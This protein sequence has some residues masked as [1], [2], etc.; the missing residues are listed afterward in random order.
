MA[1]EVNQIA[2]LVAVAGAEEVVE[3]HFQQCRERSIGGD[4]AADAVVNLVLM[5]HHGHGI[6]AHQ[7]FQFAL[8]H[9]VSGVGDFA[10]RRNRIDVVRGTA[11]R[12]ID[13]VVARSFSKLFEDVVDPVGSCCIDD[14]IQ[15]FQPLRCFAGVE[16]WHAF[17]PLLVHGF[18]HII[19][20]G[21]N[22]TGSLRTDAR[23]KGSSHE[24]SG[25][26]TFFHAVRLSGQKR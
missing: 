2:G 18:T 5:R 21:S 13:A 16:V 12:N 11:N 20:D 8:Q 26:R 19:S 15:S 4:V 24:K 7:T 6:P 17:S 14:L 9:T 25:G 22:W 23:M 10:L 1:L 3:T